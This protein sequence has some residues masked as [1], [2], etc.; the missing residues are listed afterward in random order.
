M[1]GKKPFSTMNNRAKEDVLSIP[2]IKKKLALTILLLHL[3][4]NGAWPGEN[5]DKVP[6][7]VVLDPVTVTARGSEQA[8]SQTPGGVGVVS[9]DELLVWQPAG[10]AD[11]VR[12]LP[13]VEKSSD[14]PWGAE[15]N[16]RGLGRDAVVF[17]IDGC[18]VNTAT[19]INARFGLVA[20]A[21]IER[22]EVLKGPISALYGTGSTG[23]VVNVITKKGAAGPAS[24]THGQARVSAAS[25]PAGAETY[26]NLRSGADNW[27]VF[28]SGNY[29]DAG[30]YEAGG[31]VQ[32][33]NSQFTDYQGRVYANAQWNARNASELRVL[34]MEGREIGIPGKG[35]ALPTGPLATYSDIGHSMANLVHT[36]HPDVDHWEESTLNLYAQQIERRVRLDHFPSGTVKELRPAADHVTWGGRWQNRLEASGHRLVTGVEAW[37]WQVENTERIRLLTNGN[38]GIDSSLGDVRQVSAGVFAEDTWPL[39]SGLTANAGGRWD[40]IEDDCNDLYNWIKPPT[41]AT[42][43]VRKRTAQTHRENSWNAHAGLTWNWRQDWTMTLIGASSYRAP[44]LMERYKY[45][46]LGGGTELYGNPGLEPER[47]YFGES[48]LHYNRGKLKWS[49][50]LFANFLQDLITEAALSATMRQMANVDRARLCGLESEGQ[51]RLAKDWTAFANA[52]WIEGRNTTADDD[53]DF[54]APLHGAGGVRF[55]PAEG[56]TGQVEVQWAAEQDHVSSATPETGAW[57]T[58]NLR[59]GYRFAHRGLDHELVFGIDNLLDKDYRNALSTSR[60]FELKEPGINLRLVWNIGF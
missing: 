32:V 14:S 46:N 7:P 37:Q 21:D 3:A 47:S 45:I 23:G 59:L 50:A 42:A 30:S 13:G 26:A 10:I 16:I 34:L 4:V 20:P 40:R 43:V 38:I 19:D 18:R 9:A 36:L 15:V 24:G 39:V 60:G 28:A 48:A 29:R 12:H 2:G 33:P 54:I 55:Q 51:Y 11:A 31:G 58:V 57:A 8:V 41:A 22:I 35:L 49:A 17:L 56:F 52:A 53:L 6:V 27:W 1:I 5:G 44:D 25:N